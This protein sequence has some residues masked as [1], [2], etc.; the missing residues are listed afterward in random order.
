VRLFLQV[1]EA[2][3]YLQSSIALLRCAQRFRCCFINHIEFGRS[4]KLILA[5]QIAYDH[6]IFTFSRL[7]R[8]ISVDDIVQHEIHRT[9]EWAPIA[10]TPWWIELDAGIW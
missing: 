2:V 3:I 5:P 7:K 1:Q 9:L 10:T 4:H 8:Y 6:A